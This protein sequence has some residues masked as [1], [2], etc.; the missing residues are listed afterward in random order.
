[1]SGTFSQIYIQIV[2]AVKGRACLIHSH[3]EERLYMYISGIVKSKGQKMFAINGTADHIHL[4]IGI[5]PS[6]CIS[7]LVREIKKASNEFIN[8]NNQHRFKFSWQEGYGAF[9]YG[10]SQIDVVVKYIMNQKEHHR[11]K[12][13]KDEYVAF[14]RKFEIDFDEKFLFSWIEDNDG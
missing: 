12:S 13:F 11:K 14:L 7:D 2:F 5:K 3:F 9:S 8:Q 4:F 1:M 10:H 6:C